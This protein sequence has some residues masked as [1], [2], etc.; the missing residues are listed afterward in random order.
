[1]AA[2]KS[3]DSGVQL[4]C[5]RQV[6]LTRLKAQPEQ[7]QNHIHHSLHTNALFQPNN[8]IVFVT[9]RLDGKFH[10]VA[11]TMQDPVRLPVATYSGAA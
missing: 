11:I 5:L 4:V 2:P 8:M 9:L 1:M 10:Q 6:P 3:P 7:L